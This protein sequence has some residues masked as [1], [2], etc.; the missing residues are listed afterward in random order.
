MPLKQ[1]PVVTTKYKLRLLNLLCRDE[2]S[3]F[4]EKQGADAPGV[5]TL[6]TSLSTV[7]TVASLNVIEFA[8]KLDFPRKN[9]FFCLQ[10][11]GEIS[12][13]MQNLASRVDNLHVEIN[14]HQK[15]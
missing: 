11:P 14:L 15:W 7:C 13:T 1:L 4:M 10:Q 6:T 8:A 2:L 9:N 3:D 12:L 5:L